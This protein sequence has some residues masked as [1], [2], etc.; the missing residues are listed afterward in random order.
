M[1]S[2]YHGHKE[3][4]KQRIKERL[5]SNFETRN[6]TTLYDSKIITQDLQNEHENI[7]LL[8]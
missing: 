5:K 3:S 7:F 6:K 4:Q 8:C 2:S 1:L